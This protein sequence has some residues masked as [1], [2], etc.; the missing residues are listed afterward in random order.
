MSEATITLE[1]GTVLGLAQMIRLAEAIKALGH[2]HW[3][4]NDCGC[5]VTVHGHD[6]SVVIGPDGGETWFEGRGCAC[7]DDVQGQTR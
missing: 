2:S 1:D 4:K 3:H 7:S 6:R 5:C